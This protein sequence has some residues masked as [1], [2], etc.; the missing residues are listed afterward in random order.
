MGMFRAC[1]IAVSAFVLSLAGEVV[2]AQPLANDNEIQ[3]TGGYFRPIGT[4]DGTFNA[5][6]SYG[7]FP[8]T[9]AWEVGIRQAITVNQID[10]APDTWVA[11]TTPFVDYHFLGDKLFGLDWRQDLVP[12]IGGF[13]GAVWNDDDFTG[14]VGPSAGMKFF[15]NSQTFL[16]AR[17]NYEWFFDELD[18]FNDTLDANHVLTISL[19][20]LWG[21][22]RNNTIGQ[23]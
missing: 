19:G 8:G 20:Y 6:I 21:G 11:T 15:F 10:E 12:F 14:T 17:Y 18:Q 4:G 13:I 3:V 7:Y 1:A 2:Q 9:A 22:Q 23:S 16:S 5:Q